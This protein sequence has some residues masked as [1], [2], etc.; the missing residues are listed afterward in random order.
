VDET[1]VS[2]SNTAMKSEPAPGTVPVVKWRQ[3]LTLDLP[4]TRTGCLWVHACSMGEINSIALLVRWLLAQGHDVH[5]TVVTRTGYHQALRL[6]GDSLTL[7]YLP[8]DLPGAMRRLVRRLQPRLLLLTETEFWPGMLTACHRN[9]IPIVGINT[10]ISDRSF[11]RYLA[12]RALWRRW[13]RPVRLFLAQSDLDASRLTALGIPDDR[14]RVAGNLK[15][16]I[17]PPEVDT[18]ALRR[19]LDPSGSRPVLL[20]ASTHDDEEHRLLSMLPGWRIEVPDLL[21]VI[22][23]R[24]P[25]RFDT[26]A[27]IITD[28]GLP[29]SRWSEPK[30]ERCD[31]CLVDA[32]GVLSSLYTV[33]DLVIIGGSLAPVG[34]HNPLEAAICGRG[35]VTGPH[36]E[37]FRDVM[38]QMQAAGAA[39]LASDD[40][41]LD[42]VIGRFL[43]HPAELK[44]LHA[45]SAA[46]MTDK[47]AV[48]ERITAALQPF[49]PHSGAA[50]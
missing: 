49:L 12:T 38:L 18:D 19:R 22:V 26:V 36:I 31:I 39:V 10:R 3:H 28:T 7:S 24:H 21:T 35:V 33:A 11:P 14:I 15:F 47:S 48:L 5:L 4:A 42:A 41:E 50:D 27:T 8:W 43:A 23:P 37:N 17:R 1:G 6:F 30:P 9:D 45:R 25:E 32:M 34:G 44:E 13:L 46:F 29:A 2:C 40:H 16:A 20:I